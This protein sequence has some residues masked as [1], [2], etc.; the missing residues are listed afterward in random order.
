MTKRNTWDITVG[1]STGVLG[2]HGELSGLAFQALQHQTDRPTDIL[3]DWSTILKP[4]LPFG[5]LFSLTTPS[6]IISSLHPS[7]S[8]TSLPP[9]T[10][11]KP[12]FG[13]FSQTHTHAQKTPHRDPK[14]YI[15]VPKCSPK[16]IPLLTKSGERSDWWDGLDTTLQRGRSETEDLATLPRHL[17]YPDDDITT[18]RDLQAATVIKCD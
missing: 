4:H 14:D 15:S 1:V 12:G 9:L 6:P 16:S 8:S 17:R 10:T 13:L 5:P 11:L 3:I 18:A 2:R 7:Q